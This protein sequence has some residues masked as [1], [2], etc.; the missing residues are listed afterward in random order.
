V[1]WEYHLPGLRAAIQH[2][3][4]ILALHGSRIDAYTLDAE[5]RLSAPRTLRLGRAGH[6]LAAAGD[7]VLVA[8]GSGVSIYDL[9]DGEL[10][11]TI[12]ICGRPR[13][14]F[15]DGSRAYVVGLLRLVVLDVADPSAPLRLK[16]VSLAPRRD[17]AV[18]VVPGG[19]CGFLERAFDRLCEATGACGAFGRS[20]AAFHE[21]KLFL[22]LLGTIH[23]LDM[24]VD[25]GPLL[26]ASVPV[27]FVSRMAVEPPFVYAN[28]V[29]DR[30]FVVAE[31]PDGTWSDVG[32][33]DVEEF[34]DGVLQLE[35]WAVQVDGSR[36]RIGTIQ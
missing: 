1:A 14:V 3:G 35:H 12:E 27:G 21:G 18:D 11:S 28:G 34:V 9:A 16:E 23:V 10:L 6:D 36:M 30:T 25:I 13:R 2:R 4:E 29:C 8:D 20:A 17:A 22:H 15:V 19:R 33:H 7:A 26:M 24:R 31:L 5:G 32:E